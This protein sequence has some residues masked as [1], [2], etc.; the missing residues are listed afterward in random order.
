MSALLEVENLTVA[1][2]TRA[3]YRNAVDDLSL[4]VGLGEVVGIAG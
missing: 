2:P 1:L 3:G 4:S